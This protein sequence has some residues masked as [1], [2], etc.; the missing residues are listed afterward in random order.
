MECDMKISVMFARVAVAMA[1]LAGVS[2]TVIAATPPARITV[3]AA[4]PGRAENPRMWGVF[5]ENICHDVDG[6]LYAQMIRNPD[7]Q[8]DVPPAD[9]QVVAGRWR[10]VN[11]HLQW[12]PHFTREKNGPDVAWISVNGHIHQP[13]PGGP[14]LA[15]KPLEPTPGSVSLLIEKQ[16]PLSGAHPLSLQVAAKQAGAG[17]ANVGYWGMPIKKGRAYQVSFYARTPNGTAAAVQAS[18]ANANGTKHF[19]HTAVTIS[20]SAWRRYRCT[21]RADGSTYH[22][23]LTLT[24]TA[25]ATFDINLV[26]MF[27]VSEK[28]GKAE[29]IRHDLL[30]LLK[31]LHPGFLRFP[32]GNYIEGYSLDDSYNWRQTVGPMIDRPGHVNYWGYRDTDGFGYLGWLELAQRVEA[33]PLYCTS[34]GL[35]HSAQTIPGTNLNK[36]INEM[37]TA[38]AFANDPGDTRF[39]A[40]R[41]Q[42]GH[43][44]HFDLKYLEIGN[45]NGGPSYNRNYHI[46]AYALHKAYPGVIPIAD[47]WGGIPSGPLSMVDKHYYPSQQWFLNH[48]NLY[49]RYPRTGPKIFVGEYAVGNT[50]ARYGD[51]R[52]TL[53]ET[54]FMIGM[55]RN[56]DVVRLASYGVTLDNAGAVPCIINLIEFN[57]RTAFGRSSYWVQYLFNHNKPAV[58]YPTHVQLGVAVKHLKTPRLFAD[59]GV[60]ANRR[61]LIIKVVNAS[62]HAMPASI[63][64]HG[65][66]RIAH[67]GM[68]ITLHERNP[69]LDNTFNHPNRVVP[70][71]APCGGLADH[72]RY[73]FRPYC[74]TILRVPIAGVKAG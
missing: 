38:V 37:L 7:F 74:V 42:C 45:E 68:A 1:L 41:A 43:P 4:V 16:K 29:F 12:P 69:G 3:D 64:L 59:A 55:E 60:T 36:Y 70:K 15:W 30:A 9:C 10:K 18:L 71:T 2:G 66:T 5:I 48:T 34:A 56:C 19:A 17:V 65:F 31:R 8:N 21:L 22:G 58:V 52:S 25:P 49:N 51:F 57:D 40:L 53:A 33:Q 67:G 32:G 63:D 26:L 50:H 54:A 6:G 46:M 13:P 62:G 61:V 27:P 23:A 11:G 39:G 72:F 24:A 20:G 44:A 14:L 73:T 47:D 35:L 28:T